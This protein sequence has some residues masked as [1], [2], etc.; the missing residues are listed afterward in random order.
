MKFGKIQLGTFG[1]KSLR[2]LCEDG[3]IIGVIVLPKGAEHEITYFING[4]AVKNKG[5]SNKAYSRNVSNFSLLLKKV[6]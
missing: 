5:A 6:L 2:G 4:K 1:K 3:T